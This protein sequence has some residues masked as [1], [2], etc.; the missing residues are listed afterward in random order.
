MR[1]ERKKK[2]QSRKVMVVMGCNNGMLEEEKIGLEKKNSFLESLVKIGQG[3]QEIFGVFGSAIGDVL[4]FNVVKSGDKRSKVGEHFE[5]IKK[6]LEGINERLKGLVGEISGAKNADVSTIEV[7]KGSIK[8]ANE[9][10]GQLIGALTKLAG[11]TNDGDDI[12]HNDNAAA[13]GA[14]EVSV[15]TIIAEVKNIIDIAEKSG[16]KIDAGNA[17]GQVTA[18]NNTAA[19]A[20]FGGH[21]NAAAG[22]GA[23]DK[24]A[25]E[26]S[27]ADPWAMIDKIKNA[28]ATAPVTLA[29]NNN[30]E[31]GTLVAANANANNNNYGVKTNADLAAAVALKA[32]TKGGKF[33]PDNGDVGAVKAAAASAV[34]KVLGILDVI[35]RKI[36]SSNLE[37]VREAVKGIKDSEISGIN[38]PEAGTTQPIANN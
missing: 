28:T 15:K 38:A 12:G 3:F 37:K 31:V 2:R 9:V 13:A 30:H 23:G 16:V 29:A 6:G 26:V 19:P 21:N 34:N 4:G 1:M 10:F 22:A 36:V 7:V 14:E 33:R 5:K 17:G 20:V 32:M 11:V 35:I 27:K 24:L 8:G 25:S 18:A